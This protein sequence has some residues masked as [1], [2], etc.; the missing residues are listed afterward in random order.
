MEISGIYRYK[1]YIMSELY[2]DRLIINE[3]GCHR[4]PSFVSQN[5]VYYILMLLYVYYYI[6]VESYE[7]Q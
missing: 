3:H 4:I 7:V 6:F 2:S 1:C 5:E